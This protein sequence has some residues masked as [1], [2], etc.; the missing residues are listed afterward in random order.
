MTVIKRLC[1]QIINYFSLVITRDICLLSQMNHQFILSQINIYILCSPL[2]YSNGQSGVNL[3]LLNILKINRFE[4]Q[5]QINFLINMKISQL[6]FLKF[7]LIL[8]NK[9]INDSINHTRSTPNI[10]SYQLTPNIILAK[11]IDSW[12]IRI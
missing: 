4:Y 2:S 8:I 1:H 12:L 10:G 11:K 3:H 5:S 9:L 7:H 6:K